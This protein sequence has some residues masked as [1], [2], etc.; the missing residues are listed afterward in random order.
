MTD[1]TKDE[2]KSPSVDDLL[3]DSRTRGL[4]GTVGDNE[5]PQD[6][7]RPAADRDNDIAEVYDEAYS[8]E[9]AAGLKES[10]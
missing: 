6:I 9:Q 8:N 4:A 1:Q 5:L 2:F 3:K 7:S 10:V